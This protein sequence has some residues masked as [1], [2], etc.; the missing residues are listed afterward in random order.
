MLLA[1]QIGSK[2]MFELAAVL[3]TRRQCVVY[4]A[5]ATPDAV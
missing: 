2:A 4:V 1:A 3:P 5:L